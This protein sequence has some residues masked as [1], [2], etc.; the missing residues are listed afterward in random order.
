MRLRFGGKRCL[1]SFAGLRE[2][3]MRDGEG[4]STLQCHPVRQYLV[5]TFVVEEPCWKWVGLEAEVVLVAEEVLVLVVVIA[6]R[7]ISDR[8]MKKHNLETASE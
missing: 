5:L 3:S 1:A 7:V 8:R 6:E 2:P 4:H